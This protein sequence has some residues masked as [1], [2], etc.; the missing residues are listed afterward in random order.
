M[1]T[2]QVAKALVR[3]L[4]DGTASSN[5]PKDW[6]LKCSV[7]DI[8][9]RVKIILDGQVQP[10]DKFAVHRET[11]RMH[12]VDFYVANNTWVDEKGVKHISTK[13]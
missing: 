4:C 6:D 11:K 12:H 9:E 13:P 8:I 5:D 2:E 7:T 1:N 10:S 3:D